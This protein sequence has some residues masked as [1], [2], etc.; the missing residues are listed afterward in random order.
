MRGDVTL[1]PQGTKKTW[2]GT[3]KSKGTRP[4]TKEKHLGQDGGSK[5]QKSAPQKHRKRK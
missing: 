3:V 4:K 5:D 2:E 1:P